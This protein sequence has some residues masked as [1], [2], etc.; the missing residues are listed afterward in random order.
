MSKKLTYFFCV[1][2]FI[3]LVVLFFFE[4]LNP[5]SGTALIQ[6]ILG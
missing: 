3:L 2:L 5:E 1:V 6:G 4:H